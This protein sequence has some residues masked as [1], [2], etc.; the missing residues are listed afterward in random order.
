[1]KRQISALLAVSLLL[2]GLT[3]CSGSTIATTGVPVQTVASLLGYDLSGNNRYAGVVESRE[4]QAVKKDEDKVIDQVNVQE[5]DEVKQGDV[6]FSY[7][8]ETLQLEL[9]TA[10][11]ELEQIENNISSYQTQV[12]ELT[13]E[14]KKASSSD[15]LSYSIQI[16]EA[17]LNISEEQYNQKK[18]Q[19]EIQD[20]Q[21]DLSHVDV[22][23]EVDGVVQSISED[24]GS[25]YMTIMET[26][27]LQVKGTA[28][29]MTLWSLTEG[30]AMTVRSR[31]DENQT[32]SGVISAINTDSTED[33]SESD[34]YYDDGASGESASKYSFTVTLNSSDGLM[35][36]QHVYLE[37][38]GADSDGMAL[39]ASYIVLEE[40]GSA[41]VWAA[42]SSD[43][44][45][46]RSV[47]LGTYDEEMDTY[48]ILDGL[49]LTDELAFPDESLEVGQSVV[50]YDASAY[51]EEG[52]FGDSSYAYEEGFD[53]EFF[54]EE[55]PETEEYE[56]YEDEGA[57]VV[58]GGETT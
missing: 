26:G 47:T 22:L 21:E 46:K 41:W 49:A 4:A 37:L 17:Q 6:L 30:E 9:E 35:I 1:M 40:D 45:K 56:T 20:L 25:A 55:E 28:S 50:L 51:S 31:L 3:G 27:V 43:R 24:S 7:D 18:K 8:A 12:N 33:D 29:E 32:W 5:G 36:G 2:W 14:K 15:Q 54:A 58:I 13:K 10:Q 57:T 39:S 48:E 44:L 11:L 53:E 52:D 23:A 42:D 19:A 16:Q 38:G 34:Y